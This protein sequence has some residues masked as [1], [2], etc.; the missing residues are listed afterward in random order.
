[1]AFNSII[2]RADAQALIPEEVTQE[3]IQNVPQ[4]SAIL[5]VARRLPN[6]PTN[7]T[8]MPIL[9]ALASAYFVNGDTGTKRTTEMEWSNRFINA[10]ELAVIV[11]IPENVLDDTS[12]DVWGEVRPRIEEA[13]GLAFDQAVMYG[14]NAPGN[15]PDDLLL[16]ATNAGHVVARG[17]I[18]DLYDDIYSENG[19]LSF[20][21]EDGFVV[22]GHIGALS[23][24]SALRS[25]RDAGGIPIF[26][27][28]MQEGSVYE[29]DGVAV[30]FPING[31]VDP[32]Q[33]LLISGDWNQLVYSIRQD[34]TYKVLDQAVIQD[35]AGN[36]VYNLAQQD[37]V[38]LRATFR[39][40][41]ELPN[42]INSVQTNEAL[43]YP[44]AVLTA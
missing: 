37:M 38:A 36:I 10:E 31:S 41:W 20:V 28:T 4:S 2:S 39:L 8:R 17:A 5:S 15:W 35:A 27:R 9:S 44:F 30:T 12:Y 21:E 14:T 42:P 33:S 7:Q 13:M 32:A 1:M 43:R 25:L 26:N 19:T 23:M 3:I 24:R 22:T 40:G 11:P 16:G 18:G 6:M 34:I 29:L